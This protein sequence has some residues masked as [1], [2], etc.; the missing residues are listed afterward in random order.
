MRGS[1]RNALAISVRPPPQATN[2]GVSVSRIASA[3]IARAAGDSTRSVRLVSGSSEPTT[4]RD[5]ALEW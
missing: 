5:L 4:D 1:S 3:T 2:R